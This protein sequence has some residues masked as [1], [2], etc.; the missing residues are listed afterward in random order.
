MSEDPNFREKVLVA[1]TQNATK[2]DDLIVRVTSINGSVAR[3][4]D[5]DR[6]H[7]QALI[8][9]QLKCSGLA[10]IKEISRK[11]SAGEYPGSK[12]VKED[13]MATEK[14]EIE[15]KVKDQTSEKWKKDLLIPLVRWVVMAIFILILLHARDMM[16]AVPK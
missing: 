9:H 15:R 10:E 16:N 11:L 13:L 14:A 4:Y 2:L 1:L 7:A 8:D 6:L 12:E 5:L 3:L